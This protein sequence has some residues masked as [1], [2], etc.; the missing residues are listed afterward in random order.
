MH[1]KTSPNKQTHISGA[2]KK[3]HSS[4]KCSSNA[5]RHPYLKADF[6]NNPSNHFWNTAL[7]SQAS[8]DYFN[9]SIGTL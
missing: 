4:G 2:Y 7:Y 8:K 6:W 9:N 5:D 3:Q 1:T